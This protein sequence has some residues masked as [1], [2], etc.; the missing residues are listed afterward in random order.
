MG[1]A[2]AAPPARNPDMPVHFIS[3]EDDPCM[4]N[5]KGFEYAIHRIRKTGAT[6]VTWKIY[7]G[8]RHEIHNEQDR[9]LVYQDILDKLDLWMLHQT[10]D[11]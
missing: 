8:M 1:M 6:H 9:Q 4:P 11:A 5:K 2:Y 10:Q 7:P 3:G